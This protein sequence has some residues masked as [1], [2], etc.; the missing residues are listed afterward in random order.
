MG[1]NDGGCIHVTG[2][3]RQWDAKKKALVMT[4]HYCHKITAPDS[5]L[6]PKHEAMKQVAG[7]VEPKPRAADP[8]Y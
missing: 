5:N 7:P 8:Y 2:R 4:S 1:E 3:S 6:C